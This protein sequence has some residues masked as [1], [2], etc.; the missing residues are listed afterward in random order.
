M[1]LLRPPSLLFAASV[2]LLSGG[3]RAAESAD[4]SRFFASGV[5][6][7]R[8]FE[9]E[10]ALEQFKHARAQPHG[11]DQDV[12]VSLYEGIL[13]YELGK[14]EE[15][16]ASFRSALAMDLAA[17][18][19][20]SVSPVIELAFQAEGEKA[21]K[22][23]LQAPAVAVA[24]EPALAA[25]TAPP[26]MT[27]EK[28][29]PRSKILPAV[30]TALGAAAVIG[31]GVSLGMSW[32]KHADYQDGKLTRAEAEDAQLD[33]QAGVGVAVAGGVLLAAG[34]VIFAL[35]EGNR[36]S[37][38]LVPVRDGAVASLTVTLP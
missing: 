27:E 11:A 14:E 21:R 5:A 4:F 15:A 35:P 25:S 36:A 31:G 16:R 24:P 17:K 19:P 22:M 28:A 12:Q 26:A 34:V 20:V 6:M 38:A 30:L 1:A 29:A 37:A 23:G 3:V 9:F 13:L 8:T 32:A 7:Y 18:L 10:R 2:L 33:A